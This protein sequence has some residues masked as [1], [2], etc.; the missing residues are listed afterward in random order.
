MAGCQEE[1]S[2]QRKNSGKKRKFYVAT[3]KEKGTIEICE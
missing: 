1:K 2:L 3:E